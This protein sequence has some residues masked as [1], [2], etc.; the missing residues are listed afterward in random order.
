MDLLKSFKRFIGWENLMNLL[1]KSISG[2]IMG[3]LNDSYR[4]VA[5]TSSRILKKK[6]IFGPDVMSSRA[7]IWASPLECWKNLA[8]GPFSRFDLHGKCGFN[9]P[10]SQ[11]LKLIPTWNRKFFTTK[12]QHFEQIWHFKSPLPPLTGL[13]WTGC[14]ACGDFTESLSVSYRISANSFRGNY[15]FL[16][17]GVRQVFKGG[18]YLREETILY[19]IWKL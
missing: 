11:K 10:I 19:W 4:L 18:N 3:L 1:S 14:S 15:S 2:L 6:M 12:Y 9:K 13:K 17:V 8:W 5:V 16:E 7:L